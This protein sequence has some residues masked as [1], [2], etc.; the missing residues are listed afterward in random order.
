MPRHRV[1]HRL[2]PRRR[3]RRRT[4]CVSVATVP[5]LSTAATSSAFLRFD[6]RYLYPHYLYYPPG[7]CFLL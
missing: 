2:L 6:P 3:R 1:L 7:R 4:A 5:A